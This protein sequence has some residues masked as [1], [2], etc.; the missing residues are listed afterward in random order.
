MENQQPTG[1]AQN[2]QKKAWYKSGLGLVIA[3][4]LF[5]YF[6]LWYM[7]AKTSWSKGVKIAITIVFAF[8]NLV[9]LMSDNSNKD[10]N[11]QAG[12]STEQ[13]PVVAET[14]SEAPAQ[15][16]PQIPQA[17]FDVPSL[18]GKNIDEVKAILG[19]P[20]TYTAPTKQQ[21]ALMDIWDMEYTKDDVNLLITYNPKSKAILD[22][23]IDGSDKA[24]LLALG[25][26]QE[27]ND[28]YIVE[29]VKAIA[30][31]NEITGIKIYKKL[32]AELDGSVAYNAVAFQ[33]SNNEDY[34]W[35]NC[36]FE[37]NGGI[38]SSGYEYKTSSGIKAK[39]NLV[40]PFSEFTKD[41]ERFNFYTQKP[42]KLFIACDTNGQHRTNY[43][44]IK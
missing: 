38:I 41:G 32:S 8:I 19:S 9:A 4:L 36:R 33:V 40:I 26:L 10:T 30:K 42:E 22:Y 21:L 2:S 37:I 43:F 12:Q 13:K 24:K 15:Q 31:P 18:I 3:I 44:A 6:L 5:P 20:T 1:E 16:A 35:I 17:V 23:F 25:N 7:W 29:P 39:D 27:K 14:K 28:A 11:Q 34:G